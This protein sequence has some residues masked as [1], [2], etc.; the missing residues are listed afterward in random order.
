MYIKVLMLIKIVLWVLEQLFTG[1]FLPN[2]LFLSLL[3]K[4]ENIDFL[5]SFLA[6]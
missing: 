3:R 2:S 5:P 6:N 4:A 1:V